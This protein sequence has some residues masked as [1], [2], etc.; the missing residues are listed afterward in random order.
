M[1]PI[2]S[3]ALAASFLQ[4]ALRQGARQP[5]T[6]SGVRVTLTAEQFRGLARKRFFI[7][8]GTF[9]IFLG[10]GGGV[11]FL[12][13]N[14]ALIAVI[15]GFFAYACLSVAAQMRAAARDA[16]DVEVTLSGDQLQVAGQEPRTIFRALDR[17]GY[18]RLILKDSRVVELW[19]VNRREP[20]ASF[21]LPTSPQSRL[22]L[23][24]AL[25]AAGVTVRRESFTRRLLVLAGSVAVGLLALVLVRMAAG[26]AA[27]AII[28]SPLTWAF[29]GL[30]GVGVWWL[31]RRQD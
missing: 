5:S 8:L 14:L 2:D 11:L 21:D 26:L 1:P 25:R 18:L 28:T 12:S 16:V 15:C 23:C 19:L 29:L 4:D 6:L 3:A 20:S 7:A 13:P 22:E 30:I 17:S 31:W 10:A 9:P 27:L 24:A